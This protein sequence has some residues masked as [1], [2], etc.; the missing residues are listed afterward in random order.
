MLLALG[1]IPLSAQNYS[2][3]DSRSFD[4]RNAQLLGKVSP[5]VSFHMRSSM[6]HRKN[7]L[8][9]TVRYQDRSASDQRLPAWLQFS[10]MDATWDT[11]FNSNH[12]AGYNLGSMFA[13]KG[14][15]TRFSAG[16]YF[17]VGPLSVQLQPE[18]IYNQNR[19]FMTFPHGYSHD[20]LLIY[21]REVIDRIDMPERYSDDAFSRLLPGNS[22]VRLNLWKL[23][24]GVSNEYLWWGPGV[25][26]SLMLTS[27]AE[28]FQ[29]VT[30]NTTSPIKTPIGSFEGQYLMA[31][32]ENSGYA[33]PPPITRPNGNPYPRNKRDDWRYL[34]GIMLSWNPPYIRGLHLG[35]ARTF[36]GY[37]TLLSDFKS[38]HPLFQPFTKKQFVDD[39]NPSGND[40]YDQRISVF[41]RFVLPKNGFEFYGEFGREDHSYDI[42]DAYMQVN[43]S[44]AYNVGARKIFELNRGGYILASMEA[45]R[46]ANTNTRIVRASPTWY[47]HHVVRQGYTHRGQLIGAGI[48]PGS[49]GTW[50]ALDWYMPNGNRFGVDFERIQHNEDLYMDLFE[51][52]NK[53]RYVSIIPGFYADYVWQKLTFSGSLRVVKAINRHYW[54]T[55][56]PDTNTFKGYSPVNVNLGFSVRYRF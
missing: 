40:E 3:V 37:N 6:F 13:S 1:C 52:W 39:D 50:F 4:L 34:N 31:R 30:L 32:L 47:V 27:N 9:Y 42:R 11:Q 16:L 18:A 53:R 43:H 35:A 21:Y 44:R 56:D 49:N 33:I 41:F 48:G 5:N 7:S 25:R 19:S 46:L 51:P 2:P 14:V 28:G 12:P 36:I 29:H 45:T 23:S 10:L 26:N 15:N 54:G 38:Y 22:S 24:L 20:K 17:A 55:T 8:A